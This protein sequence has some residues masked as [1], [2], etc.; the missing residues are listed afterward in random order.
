[1]YKN[2]N[3]YK[4]S[5]YNIVSALSNK[6]IADIL[7]EQYLVNHITTNPSSRKYSNKLSSMY[8]IF[9][10]VYYSYLDKTVIIEEM[11]VNVLINRIKSG[12]IN[13]N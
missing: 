12:Q 3:T 1:M 4:D 5:L 11:L 9:S 13:F 7:R 8:N 2:Y 6:E 10:D